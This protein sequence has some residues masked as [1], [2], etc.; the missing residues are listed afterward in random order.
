MQL[1]EATPTPPSGVAT[2]QLQLKLREL[3]FFRSRAAA[4][5]AKLAELE[6]CSDPELRGCARLLER[7]AALERQAKEAR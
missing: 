5:E 4:L 7:V 3:E 1:P 6:R 2:T